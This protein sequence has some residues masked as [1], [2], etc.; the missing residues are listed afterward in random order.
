MD[1]VSSHNGKKNRPPAR[2][3]NPLMRHVHKIS[4]FSPVS[5]TSSFIERS[6]DPQDRCNHGKEGV[7]TP[8][9]LYPS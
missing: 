2:G 8:G 7:S 5:V 1:I 9:R 3:H 6:R 4:P